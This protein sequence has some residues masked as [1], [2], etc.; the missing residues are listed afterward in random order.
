MGFKHL[1][2]IFDQPA[3]TLA[4]LIFPYCAAPADN[5]T[6]YEML[7][8]VSQQSK[9]AQRQIAGI[10]TMSIYALQLLQ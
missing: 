10:T 1:S 5:K 2:W 3:M 8:I 4:V 6:L 9:Q 7:K